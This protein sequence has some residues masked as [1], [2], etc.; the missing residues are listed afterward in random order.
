M[1]RD[2]HLANDLNTRTVDRFSVVLAFLPLITLPSAWLWPPAL[3]VSALALLLLGAL[4]APLFWFFRRKKGLL[5]ALG[6]IPL[7]WVYLLVCGIGFSI[8]L[9]RHA[10]RIASAP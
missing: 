8:G 7:Y 4:N 6:T 10:T 5:F 3:G 1:L 2:R 9:F